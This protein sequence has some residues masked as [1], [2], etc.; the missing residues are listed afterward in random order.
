MTGFMPRKPRFINGVKRHVSESIKL[1][2]GKPRLVGGELHNIIFLIYTCLSVV[3]CQA[4][5][6]GQLISQHHEADS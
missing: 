1:N 5:F 4:D 3:K 2:P 6:K